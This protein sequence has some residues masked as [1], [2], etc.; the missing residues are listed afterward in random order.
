VSALRVVLD[1]VSG[2]WFREA[3]STTYLPFVCILRIQ[4]SSNSI[5]AL[6]IEVQIQIKTPF[7]FK[8]LSEIC[9]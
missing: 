6:E 9:F 8:I 2:V 7:K 5:L 1:A 4:K 3:T